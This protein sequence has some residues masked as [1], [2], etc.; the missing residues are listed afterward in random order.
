VKHII[1]SSLIAILTVTGCTYYPHITN[2]PLIREKGDTRFELGVSA[3]PFI[4][5]S[6]AGG[7]T[8]NIAFQIAGDI[9]V[10]NKYV[11]GAAG[12]YKNRDNLKITELY[13]GFGWGY[14]ESRNDA[15][16]GDMYGSSLIHFVQFNRGAVRNNLEYG[17]GVKSGYMY[18]IMRDH[19][20]YAQYEKHEDRRQ[21]YPGVFKRNCLVAG[22][23][24]GRRL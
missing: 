10:A 17:F 19:N 14:S 5:A 24:R 21:A 15:N 9:G 7:L 6:I 18:S 12:F 11:Q 1:L 8:D 3:Y 2:I 4:R 20:F 23:C 16:P 22:S 13:G